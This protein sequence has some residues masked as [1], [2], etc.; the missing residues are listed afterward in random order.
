[1]GAVH[2]E[3]WSQRSR[4]PYRHIVQGNEVPAA[5]RDE[6]VPGQGRR[7]AVRPQHAHFITFVRPHGLVGAQA[8]R[9]AARQAVGA[10]SREHSVGSHRA[11]V[12]WEAPLPVGGG[13]PALPTPC[14]RAHVFVRVLQLAARAVGWTWG[15]GKCGV[16]FSTGGAGPSRAWGVRAAVHSQRTHVF[17]HPIA[18]RGGLAGGGR[19]LYNAAERALELGPTLRPPGAATTFTNRRLN[20][21]LFFARPV[22]AFAFSCFGTLG[23]WFFTLPARDREPCTLPAPPPPHG[24]T[25]AHSRYGKSPHSAHRPKHASTPNTTQEGRGWG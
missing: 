23:V 14:V 13:A 2:R 24:T 7:G 18:Q 5:V 16:H 25:G 20:C 21:C 12:K 17:T 22:A 19:A 4:T 8:P 1:M 3:G 15:G 10:H 11:Q 6:P 9:S